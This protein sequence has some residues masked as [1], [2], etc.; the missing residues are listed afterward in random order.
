MKSCFHRLDAVW[1]GLMFHFRLFCASADRLMAAVSLKISPQPWIIVSVLLT[2]LSFLSVFIENKPGSHSGA[3]VCYKNP[4]ASMQDSKEV[5]FTYRILVWEARS[6]SS[7]H[8]VFQR[9]S[10][11]HHVLLPDGINRWNHQRTSIINYLLCMKQQIR[12]YARMH[13]NIPFLL[14]VKIFLLWAPGY[15]HCELLEITCFYLQCEGSVGGGHGDSLSLT[16]TWNVFPAR[17]HMKNA[18]RGDERQKSKS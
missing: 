16:S 3:A 11:Q 12:G 9:R 8:H 5:R 4:A 10:V 7:V 15:K 2:R 17:D 6:L 18:L 1:K 13:Q 14:E